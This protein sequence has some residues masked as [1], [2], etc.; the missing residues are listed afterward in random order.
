MTYGHLAVFGLPLAFTILALFTQSPA[1]ASTALYFWYLCYE[2]AYR[3]LIV[4]VSL[5]FVT[6]LHSSWSYY[7]VSDSLDVA[8]VGYDMFDEA[9][10]DLFFYW[11]SQAMFVTFIN[12]RAF[13]Q[14]LLGLDEAANG[15][16]TEDEKAQDA[17]NVDDSDSITF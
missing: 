5:L 12:K 1:Q 16:E 7:V 14:L 9:K 10:S 15:L 6:M 2:L 4:G 8:R 3:Y 17:S 13:H 11:A